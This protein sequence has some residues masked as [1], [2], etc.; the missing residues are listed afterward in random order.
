MAPCSPGRALRARRAPTQVVAGCRDAARG[1]W[2]G[3][4]RGIP[5]PAPAVEAT[6]VGTAPAGVG[7]A[8]AQAV[9]AGAPA[10][11]AAACACDWAAILSAAASTARTILS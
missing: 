3:R 4:R 7:R 2:A 5:P 10:A 11:G 6:P 1:R 9:G 8:A